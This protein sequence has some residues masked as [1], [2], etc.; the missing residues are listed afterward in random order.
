VRHH[1]VPGGR[2]L[3]TFSIDAFDRPVEQVYD[4]VAK[5]VAGGEDVGG[6]VVRVFVNNARTEVR[7]LLD[8]R[9]LAEAFAD[10]LHVQVHVDTVGEEGAAQHAAEPL[11]TLAGEWDRYLGSIPIEGYDRDRLAQ[12]GRDLLERVEEEAS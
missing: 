9:V 8:R 2:S 7:R 12:L 10:A 1:P 11:T 6:A 5:Q 4:L 3:L